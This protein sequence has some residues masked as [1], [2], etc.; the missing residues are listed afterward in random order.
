VRNIVNTT[1]DVVVSQKMGIF[2]SQEGLCSLELDKLMK[3]VD[4][5]NLR[6]L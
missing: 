3:G 4:L 6:Y 5:K 1:L 2:I